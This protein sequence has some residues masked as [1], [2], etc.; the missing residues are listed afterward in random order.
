MHIIIYLIALLE[1]FTTL[2]VEITALRIFSPIIWV[3]SISTSII[4]WV[5]LLALS[6]WY[7]IWWKITARTSKVEKYLLR[8]LLF[9]SI[10]YFFLTFVFS[11]MTLE[12]FL[13]VIPSYT[14][15]ILLTSIVL[16]FIPVFLASQTIPLLSELLK[17]NHS[18]EKIW[19]LLFYSTIGSFAWSVGTSVVLFPTIWVDKTAIISPLLLV[20]CWLLLLVYLKRNNGFYIVWFSSLIILYSVI[21]MSDIKLNSNTIYKTSNAY[22]T[23]EIYNNEYNQRIF[24]MDGA[25]SSGINIEN[26]ESFFYYIREIKKQIIESNSKN[27]LIIWAA[28][29]T[30]PN[31]LSQ[32]K[33]IENIDVIDIDKDLKEIS[34]KYFLQK[35]LSDKIKFYP[36]SARFYLNQLNWKQYDAVVVDAYSW[37]SLPSQILTVE[38]F[39]K[40]E[41]ISDSIYLN[42]I[43]DRK[44]ESMFAKKL[45]ATIYKWFWNHL[46]YKDVNL[47]NHQLTNFVI[48]NKKNDNYL[49]FYWNKQSIYTDNKHTIELDLFDINS[50]IWQ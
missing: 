42:M 48:T 41:H 35:K 20:I 33:S 44:L 4:L 13:Q 10:Y 39:E 9:S 34:E 19:K 7:Y 1:G 15:A 37:Q 46:Y 16:F 18:W 2:S 14:L 49:K 12:L 36:Q 21:L 25:Y 23:I 32:I 24:S 38:F 27:I 26:S 50:K 31:E 29:F 30:L 5:I 28:W 6:Y 3:N 17:W 11:G 8:N 47:D 43:S 45:F 22:H 40:L